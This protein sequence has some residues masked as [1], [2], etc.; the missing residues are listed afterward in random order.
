LAGLLLPFTYTRVPDPFWPREVQEKYPAIPWSDF[1]GMR[2]VLIHGY[3]KTNWQT[4]WNTATREM[5]DLEVSLKDIL[6][7]FP[8]PLS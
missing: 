5:D 4:V 6:A 7:A 1:I 3:V 8:W 2:N